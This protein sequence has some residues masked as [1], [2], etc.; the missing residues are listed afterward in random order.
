MEKAVL[1]ASGMGTRLRPFTEKTP[2]P[3][4]EVCGEPMVETLI[5]SLEKRGVSEII[6]VVGHLGEQFAYLKEKYGNIRLVEN[7]D[8]ETVNNISSVYYAAEWMRNCDCFICEA[9]LYVADKTIVSYSIN[10]SCYY[11]CM[12][13]GISKDW[14]FSLD[15]EGY[16]SRVGKGGTDCFQMV[17]IAYFKREDV[18]RLLNRICETYGRPGFEKLFWDDVVN[19]HLDEL[20]LKIHPVQRHQIM[21]IDTVEEWKQVNEML[22][23]K[24]QEKI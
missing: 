5:E 11:G 10:S 7:P 24:R 9:D 19:E 23:K 18:N 15:E 17:G 12:V 6:V 22:Q 2:K 21:E 14:V 4:L 20:K 16:I 1:M 8:Y 3:L 13:N